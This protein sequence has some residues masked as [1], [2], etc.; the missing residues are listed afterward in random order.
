MSFFIR[1]RP[2]TPPI[3]AITGAESMRAGEY[4]SYYAV[5]CPVALD[6]NVTKIVI[7]SPGDYGVVWFHVLAGDALVASMNARF[8]ALVEYELP[9]KDAGAPD[10]GQE[11]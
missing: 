10:G 5:G 4:P 3:R 8:V 6:V 11:R 7:W 9:A 2:T 1:G